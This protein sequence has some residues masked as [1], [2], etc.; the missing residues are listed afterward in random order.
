MLAAFTVPPVI[1]SS[2]STLILPPFRVM[3]VRVVLD[4]G[5]PARRPLVFRV[6]SP[7]MVTV[8]LALPLTEYVSHSRT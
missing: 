1:F 5:S 6:P 7:P 2:P 4:T 8:A 3:P